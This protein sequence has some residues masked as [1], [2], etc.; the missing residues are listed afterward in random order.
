MAKAM[1]DRNPFIASDLICP[2]CGE[3]IHPE[4]VKNLRGGVEMLR[5]DH[6]NEEHGC[7]YRIETNVMIS[8]ELRPIREDG[9]EAVL[10][11]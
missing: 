3:I 5:Y 1:P 10:P 4:A 9:S 2:T 7:S 11:R 6:K 8:S